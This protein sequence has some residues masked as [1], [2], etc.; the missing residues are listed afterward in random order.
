MGEENKLELGKLL[1][2]AVNVRVQTAMEQPEIKLN[3]GS[4]P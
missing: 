1:S 2:K 3:R 4:I